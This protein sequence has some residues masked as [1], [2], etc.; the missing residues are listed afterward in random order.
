MFNGLRLDN[1][2]STSTSVG[3]YMMRKG[4]LA[5]QNL[6]IF[7]ELFS[8]SSYIDSLFTKQLGLNGIVREVNRID[9]S[10]TLNSI[11]HFHSGNGKWAIGSLPMQTEV[12]G[13][14]R[15]TLLRS[16]YAPSLVYEQSHDNESLIHSHGFKHQLPISA[17][18]AFS[19]CMK[20]TVRG[21]DQ[22]L[23]KRLSVVTER[24]QYTLPSGVTT[25]EHH[26]GSVKCVQ[27][28]LDLDFQATIV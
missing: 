3:G 9:D 19:K 18:I 27:F 11:L 28:R 7:A 8:G 21:Y 17:L 14:K 10:S 5:N 23:E 15:Y 16:Q 20:G 4:R 25:V 22:Y 24:R 26:N 13:E 6:L 2:H 1:A 12:Y